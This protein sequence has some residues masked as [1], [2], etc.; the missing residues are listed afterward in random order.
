MAEL[1]KNAWLGWRSFTEAGKLPALL[2]ASLIALWLSGQTSGKKTL[3]IYTSIAAACCV[4]PVT[5]AGLM[6]YQTKF[7]DYQWVWSFVPMTA[8]IAWGAVEFLRECWPGLRS[9]EWKKGLPGVLFLVVLLLLSSGAGGVS[10]ED[11]TETGERKQAEELLSGIRENMPEGEICLWAPKEILEYAREE[12]NPVQ[13]LYG[14]NMWDEWLNAYSYDAPS[15][16]MK[17]LYQWMEEE[18]VTAAP[19]EI[20]RSVRTAVEAG[21]NCVLLPGEIQEN[22]VERVGRALHMNVLRLGD[23]YFLDV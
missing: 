9:S 22:A 5:A 14:R 19:A 23:Y 12:E 18:A 10:R 1:L 3:T 15:E 4:F 7:Y 11:G 8:V 21:A 17:S 6:L 16:E 13:L 20:V 2:A